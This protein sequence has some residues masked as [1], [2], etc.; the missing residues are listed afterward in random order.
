MK[1]ISILFTFFAISAIIISCKKEETAPVIVRTTF[2]DV[3]KISAVS[4]V[5]CHLANSGANFE[6]R[7]KHVDNYTITKEY[8][9]IILDRITRDPAAAGFMPRGKPKLSD[10]EIE[11]FKKWI[12][13]GL[14]EK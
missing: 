14:L 11:L 3:A 12:S 7:K 6:A 10:A 4:C 9:T 5:P 1:K 8:A 2:A 13:D